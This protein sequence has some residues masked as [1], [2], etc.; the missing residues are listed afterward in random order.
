MWQTMTDGFSSF[1]AV[2][3]CRQ[4]IFHLVVRCGRYFLQYQASRFILEA[5]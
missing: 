1:S 2:L 3:C 5:V 4:L